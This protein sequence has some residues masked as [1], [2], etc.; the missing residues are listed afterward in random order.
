[1][2]TVTIGG[3]VLLA[4]WVG[5]GVGKGT[6]PSMVDNTQNTHVEHHHHYVPEGDEGMFLVPS[7]EDP[8]IH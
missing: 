8:T 7:K 4:F 2:L 3:L 5:Y 1:M 6:A